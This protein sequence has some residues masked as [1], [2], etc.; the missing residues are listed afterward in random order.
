VRPVISLVA[1]AIALLANG[2]AQ[3]QAGATPDPVPDSHVWLSGGGGMTSGGA[4]GVAGVHVAVRGWTAAVRYVRA[5]SGNNSYREKFL[6][7]GSI[8][9]GRT[10]PG[11][12]VLHSIALGAGRAKHWEVEY[13]ACSFDCWYGERN[14]GPTTTTG[15]APSMTLQVGMQSQPFA[16]WLAMSGQI[17]GTYS[18]AGS[19]AGVHVSLNI[20]WL[21]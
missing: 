6:E 16:R 21:R 2:Q 3:A 9:I 8:L 14:P 5:M 7:D 12:G 20:G 19:H 4:A 17:H 18:E 15:P 11:D 10:F 13:V 1:A